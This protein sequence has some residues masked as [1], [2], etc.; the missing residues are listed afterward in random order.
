MT[1]YCMVSFGRLSVEQPTGRG[2]GVSFRITNA[3]KPGDQFQ[4]FSRRSIR[5]CMPPPVETP[6]CT[7]FKRYED[8][9]KTVPLELT[10]DDVM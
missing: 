9:P 8:V 2:E 1:W 6:A 3:Q 4:S 5:T 10:E 7:S